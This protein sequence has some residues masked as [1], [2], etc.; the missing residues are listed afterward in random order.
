MTPNFSKKTKVHA[1]DPFPLISLTSS[2]TSL[3]STYPAQVV[4]PRDIYTAVSFA[5]RLFPQLTP[6]PFK[7]LCKCHLLSDASPNTLLKPAI[8]PLPPG[9]PTPDTLLFLYPMA[10]LIF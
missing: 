4:L 10:R 6:S 8:I 3:P 7:A 9:S 2:L 1:V 5:G